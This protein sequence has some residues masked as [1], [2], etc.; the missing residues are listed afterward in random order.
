MGAVDPEHRVN[1]VD[2]RRR[3]S[4]A[5]S[6]L[7]VASFLWAA[8]VWYADQRYQTTIHAI[9]LEMA[10]RRFG[11]AA[12]ELSRLLERDPHDAEAAI[13][14]GRCEKERGRTKAAAE[15]LARVAP[16]SPLAHK[17]ILARMRLFHDQG[18]FAAAEQLIEEAAQDP[19]NNSAHV[20]VLLVPIYSQLGRV[21][22]ALRLLEEW[23]EDLSLN[24]EGASE[25]A[26]DQV[27]M[28]I[29]LALKP[30]PVEQVRAYLDQAYQMAPDDDRMWLG[31]ANLALRTGDYAEATR[32]LDACLKRRPQ[33]IPV[34]S[35]RLT[36]G[37]ATTRTDLVRQALSNLPADAATAGQIRRL[38]TWLAS[39]RGDHE[40][41]RRQLERL[42]AVDPADRKALDRLV[43][44]TET[45]GQPGRAQNFR[46]KMAE[47][48]PLRA[49]YEKLFDRNQPIRDAEE[50]AQIG[51][52]LG[53][54]FEA[55][56]FLTVEIAEDKERKDL[57]QD[58]ERLS[59]RSPVAPTRGRTLAE[60][61]AHEVGNDE[62]VDVTPARRLSWKVSR[63]SSDRRRSNGHNF[64]TARQQGS[65]KR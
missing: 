23:W 49:R 58:L 20:R 26:I 22:E 1:S 56:A 31:R 11:I 60:V 51:E 18:Q 40:S 48:E 29:E 2:N 43:Q 38:G 32:W 25:R 45:A 3:A 59:R 9:E 55:R 12:R 30:N 33:D 42:V 7:G 28:H 35:A 44:L 46:A 39:Q 36:L 62:K 37:I 15:A 8:W 6:L 17:A 65:A 54:T 57:R 47:I 4:I 19:H 16:G 5:L 14:L 50:M 52:R 27:R 41:E 13:L 21:E 34:W 53:R 10:N 24:G 64:G 63:A 61:L